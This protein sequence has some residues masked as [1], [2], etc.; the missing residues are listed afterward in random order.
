MLSTTT[1]DDDDDD[2]DDDDEQC[3]GLKK[4]AAEVVIFLST[5]SNFQQRRL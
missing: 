5:V 3:H 4:L 2:D 1:Q